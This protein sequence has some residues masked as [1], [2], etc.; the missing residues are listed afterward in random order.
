MICVCFSEKFCD[1]DLLSAQNTILYHLS[2]C[3]E[4]KISEKE[5]VQQFRV[6]ISLFSE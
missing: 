1:N 3:S 4:Y 2:N 6:S 5:M